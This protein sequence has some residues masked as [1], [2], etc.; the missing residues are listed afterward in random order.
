M[1]YKGSA[2]VPANAGAHASEREMCLSVI[3]V[4]RC[5]EQDQFNAKCCRKKAMPNEVFSTGSMKPIN[6][7]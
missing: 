2:W 1:E 3:H 7:K 5:D 6:T 4:S